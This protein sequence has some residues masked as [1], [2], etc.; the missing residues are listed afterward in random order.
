MA[1]GFQ[2]G[3][4]KPP[5]PGNQAVGALRVSGAPALPVAVL[6]PVPRPV[7]PAAGAGCSPLGAQRR[8]TRKP[9]WKDLGFFNR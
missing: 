6:R 3:P 1:F 2:R 9:G 8:N 7:P 5:G 4:K